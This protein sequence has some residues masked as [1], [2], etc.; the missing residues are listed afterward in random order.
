MRADL[1]RRISFPFPGHFRRAA[2]IGEVVH[3]D[4]IGPLDTS[5]PDGYRYICTFLDDYSRYL[6]VGFMQNR[7]DL[8]TC[9]TPYRIRFAPSKILR[10]I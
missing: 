8:R 6:F 5:F 3:S 1:A 9:L 10:S 7:R 2:S 4:V